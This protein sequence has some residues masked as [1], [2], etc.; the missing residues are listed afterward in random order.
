M[1][2]SSEFCTPGF[3]LCVL[4]QGSKKFAVANW[5]EATADL[6]WAQHKLVA[7]F[8]DIYVFDSR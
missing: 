8:V 3:V 6:L 5:L 1:K 4:T 2:I 7:V